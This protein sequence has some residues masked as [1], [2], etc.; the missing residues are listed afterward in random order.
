[1]SLFDRSEGFQIVT[2]PLGDIL[3]V[4]GARVDPHATESVASNKE[5]TKIRERAVKPL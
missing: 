2:Y 3:G 1:M 5:S 4:G